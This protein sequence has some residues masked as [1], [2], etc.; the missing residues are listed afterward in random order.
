MYDLV[1]AALQA[2]QL[3]QAAQLIKQWQQ[4][5]PK[6]PWLALA[7]GQYWEAKGELERAQTTYTKLL[8]TTANTKVL[9]QAREGI[10]RVR[11]HLA[12]QREHDLNAAKAQP[13]SE[14]AGVLVLQPVVG[15]QRQE[16]AQGL[17]K[18]MQID[19]YTARTRLPSQYWR[20]HRTGAMGELRYVGEQL[21]QQRVPCFWS[22]MEDI[23][24]L[25]V[26]RVHTIQ[27]FAPQI[28]VLC[29][30]ASGQK[31]TLQLQ[32]SEI[33]QWVLGLL[34]IYE[35]VVDL[36]PWGK[37][38]RKE[39][40]QD[41]TEVLDWHLHGRGCV[42]RFCDRTYRY[43]ESAPVPGLWEPPVDG[44]LIAATAWKA[45]KTLFEQAI[46]P[47]LYRDFKGF[48][49]SALDFIDLLP[50][51]SPYLELNRSEPSPWDAAFQLYSCLRFLAYTPPRHSG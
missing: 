51:I 18:V 42:L 20:L 11:D 7:M 8:Q 40:T 36:G 30:N 22:S 49:E 27:S 35:S 47:S 33:S 43:R 28:T 48:G 25:P 24:A 1:S 14:V 12:R 10:K 32:W 38:Q 13:G 44:P 37:L 26:F 41:Y 6:D 2:Q 5:K 9:S 3:T 50:E 39:T 16:A 31:G 19:P 46:V 45:L 34:P 15:D 17:A 23:K 4:E 29:Q 21:R